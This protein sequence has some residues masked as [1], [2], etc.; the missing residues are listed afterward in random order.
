LTP[1]LAGPN[2]QP[3]HLHQSQ[4]SQL[5]PGSCGATPDSYGRSA[6]CSAG[7]PMTSR[8]AAVSST[9]TLPTLSTTPL[10]VASASNSSTAGF[11]Q[12]TLTQMLLVPAQHWQT[13]HHIQQSRPCMP[14]HMEAR[15]CCSHLRNYN[16]QTAECALPCQPGAYLSKVRCH[17]AGA[18][19]QGLF[20]GRTAHLPPQQCSS[21]TCH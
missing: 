5:H 15:H 16:L 9:V 19:L 12:G 4:C 17:T 18:A 2:H 20:R 11:A 21:A 13:A 6:S 7:F 8:A 1:A 10:Q 14:K 3:Q